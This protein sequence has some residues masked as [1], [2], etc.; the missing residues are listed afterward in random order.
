MS[1]Q[2][3]IKRL[4]DTDER[5]YIINE[6]Y[7]VYE[8]QGAPL[9]AMNFHAHNFYEVIYVM[10]GAYSAMINDR[11]YQAKKGD[12]LLINRDVMHR[13]HETEQREDVSNRIILWITPGFLSEL[14]GEDMDFT[15]CFQNTDVCAYHFP[16]YYEEM[17]QG[18]LLKLAMTEVVGFQ[19]EG[20]KEVADRG[21]LTL[22]FVYLNLLC[23]KKEYQSMGENY[24]MHPLVQKISDYIDLHLAEKIFVEDLSQV[25]HMSK[26]HFLRTF[27]EVSG[28][29]VHNYIITKRLMKAC[30]SLRQ[31]ASVGEAYE[32]SG[33]AEYTSFLRNFKRVY[34][35][36]PGKYTQYYSGS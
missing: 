6:K 5:Q 17:L 9:G 29:T 20:V 27:K 8:K 16:I 21:Y 4:A 36:S 15:Q 13:Y 11:I 25:V 30:E 31:G 10:S 28:E 33:F 23:N 32:Q 24:Y 22:F 35:I 12:F 2:E 26:Y 14:S 34:G 3:K 1:I 7:E 18:Y 19:G